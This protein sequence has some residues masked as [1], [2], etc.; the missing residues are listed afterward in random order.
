MTLTVVVSDGETY[1]PITGGT[2]V[3][4]RAVVDR[5]RGKGWFV[6][7]IS[8]GSNEAEDL[9]KPTA[10]RVDDP[11]KLPTTIQSFIEGTIS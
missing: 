7:G 8:I 9:Y 6:Y 5:L 2:S 10:R 1:D 3:C 4:T 11:A